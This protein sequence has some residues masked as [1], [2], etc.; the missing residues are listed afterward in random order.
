MGDRPLDV[1]R[2][3][4]GPAGAK[5][6]VKY[7]IIQYNDQAIPF[8]HMRGALI[9]RCASERPRVPDASGRRTV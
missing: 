7:G 2:V 4:V 9:A 1:A 3:V 8:G 5:R 6:S